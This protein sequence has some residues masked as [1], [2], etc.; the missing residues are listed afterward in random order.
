M[1]TA[2]SLAL[3]FDEVAMEALGGAAWVEAPEAEMLVCR[4]RLPG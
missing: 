4:L 2:P 3:Y 1:L